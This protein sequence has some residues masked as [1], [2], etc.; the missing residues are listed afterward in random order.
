MRVGYGNTTDHSPMH[1]F[2]LHT[3][4]SL[5]MSGVGGCKLLDVLKSY[6]LL[7]TVIFAI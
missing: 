5:I 3:C 2:Y 7:M 6:P 1:V 4:S